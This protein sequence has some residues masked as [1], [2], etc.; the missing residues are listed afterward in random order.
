MPHITVDYSDALSETFDRRGFG[1]ALHPLVANTIE[2]SVEGCKTRFRRIEE[3]VLS[4]G[5]DDIAMVHIEVGVLSGRTPEVKTELSRS[6]LA[7]TRN[8]VKPVPGCALHLSVDVS[9]L[10]RGSYASHTERLPS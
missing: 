7:L 2:G 8:F 3:S 1:L 6:V 4:D 5:T 9:D 10:A